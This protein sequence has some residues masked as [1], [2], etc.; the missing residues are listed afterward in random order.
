[1]DEATKRLLTRQANS[2]M[3]AYIRR[4]SVALGLYSGAEHP[5]IGSG[6]CVSVGERFF[7]ATAAH[8]IHHQS[9]NSI[10]IVHTNQPESERVPISALH[11]SGGERGQ[12]EDV[13][14]IELEPEVAHSLK[15][16][17]LSLDRVSENPPPLEEGWLFLFGFPSQLVPSDRAATG[18][19]AYSSIGFITLG[20]PVSQYPDSASRSLDWVL[21]YPETGEVGW[22]DRAFPMPD[23]FGVSGGS[24]WFLNPNEATPL[25]G[26][27]NA[28]W[29]GIQHS[30][31]R[32]RRLAI[33]N[34]ISVWLTLVKEHYPGL[35]AA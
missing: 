15:R 18:I 20:V 2:E 7:V 9:E 5:E 27:H 6:T 23:P 28:R 35:L 17:F 30:W 31:V 21:E 22:D 26:S 12:P 34:R 32:S 13:G 1:M 25:V 8:N 16:D 19:Y 4:H 24:I 33:G 29:V 14:L 3:A 10:S 11:W